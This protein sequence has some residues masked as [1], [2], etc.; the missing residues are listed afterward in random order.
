MK[1]KYFHI[2]LGDVAIDLRSRTVYAKGK[3][4]R[5][6]KT[7]YKLLLFLL[8]H[9]DRIVSKDE[10]SFAVKSKSEDENKLNHL[11]SMHI[12]NL[13]NKLKNSIKVVSIP[14]KGFI[15]CK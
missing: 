15:I 1:F 12:F 6:T 11:L 8:L 2:E 5:L 3:V 10:L 9:Q 13:R 14:K 4:I 7:E